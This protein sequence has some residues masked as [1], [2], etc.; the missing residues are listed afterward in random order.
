M[1][2]FVEQEESFIRD[3]IVLGIRGEVL[4]ERLLRKPT[5]TLKKATEF[6]QE[7]KVSKEQLK[8]INDTNTLKQK[9]MQ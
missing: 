6:I 5:L 7:L 1:C 4:Q 8:T 3:R 9:W 2:E